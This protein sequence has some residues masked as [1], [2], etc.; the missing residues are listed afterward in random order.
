L[1]TITSATRK[2]VQSCRWAHHVQA[3]QRLYR[4]KQTQKTV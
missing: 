3:I 1:L 4:Q 2:G